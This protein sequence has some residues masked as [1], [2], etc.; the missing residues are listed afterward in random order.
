[1][2]NVVGDAY[3]VVRAITAGVERDI[4]DAFNG[5]DR[6][7]SRAGEN[8]GDS[9]RKGFGRN[10]DRGLFSIAFQR[11]ALQAKERLSSLIRIG[12]VLGPVLTGLSGILGILITGFTSLVSTIGASLLPAL[13]VTIQSF[14]ALTQ[15]V[16]TLKLAFA[17]V[18]KAIQAGNKAQKSGASN[19]KALEKALKA[20]ERARRSLADTI[21]D[22]DKREVESKKR[23][24]EAEDELS[25][26]RQQAIED[27]QQLGFDSEDAAIAEQ[28][29]A[30]ELEKAREELA[31]VSDLPPNSRARKE[32]ELAFA[33]ADLNYRRA[34]DRNNDLKKEETK[35]AELAK[36][37]PEALIDGQANV[38][39]ALKGVADAEDALK[40]TK[41]QNARAILAATEARDDAKDAVKDVQDGASAADAY[42]DAL[43]ELSPEAQRFV[44]YIVSLREEFKKLKAA[45]GK[46][47]FP[48]LEEAIQN[49]VDNL[50]P[51]LIPLLQSTGSVLGDIAK[52]FSETITRGE[53]LERL[54][55]IWKSNE[56]VLW[57]FG[58]AASNLYE[59]LLILLD[60]ARPLTEEFSAFLAAKTAA[61]RESLKLQ[62]STGELSKK[63][64][65]ARQTL[66]DL[67][68]ILGNTF[69]GLNN[70]F[71]ENVGPGSGGQIFLD[72]LKDATKAFENLE[73][74]DGKPVREFFADA[75]VNGTKF[76]S[77][78]GNIIGGFI[79][80]TD[81]AEL[82][83]FFD[84]LNTVTDIIQRIGEDISNS[85]P[86]F[87]EFLIQFAL[88]TETLTDSGSI[89]T[90]FDILAGVLR[91]INNF[92]N[93]EFGQALLKVT[94]AILPV[95]A[96]LGFVLKVSK[97]FGKAVVGAFLQIKN[98]AAALGFVIARLK[99]EFA[100][101][102]YTLGLG[103]GP[104]LAIIAAVAALVAIVVLAYQKSEVFREALK[105]LVEGVLVALKRAFDE[106]L[107]AIQEVV[108][109]I[110]SFGDIFKKI[111]D[112]LGKYIVPL[113]EVVLVGAIDLVAG[114]IKLII[115]VAGGLIEAFKVPF[116]VIKGI[117]ALFR[118]D[119]K[120]AAD[121]FK[122]AFEAAVNAIKRIFGGLAGFFKDIINA[123]IIRPW[124]RLVGGLSFKLPGILG[125]GTISLP[126]LNELAQGGVVYPQTGGTAA[127]LAEA[128]RPERIEPLDPQ[129]LS[130]RDRAIINELAG[131]GKGT[132]V[133]VTVNPS[134]GMDEREL[135]AIVSRQI[136][137][138]LRRGAA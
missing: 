65:I 16:L 100:M 22:A 68:T 31:R 40:E 62:E 132:T 47:L 106:I 19:A 75:A 56:I 30:L 29:A 131:P 46:E 137:F 101:L 64:E 107:E 27:L 7:G 121:A 92:L 20:L 10:T 105:T 127:L 57:N 76:L 39:E 114:A 63:F 43:S 49:L 44:K 21:E 123:A 138:Q 11:S 86:A 88:I 67:G 28:K 8:V 15:A 13:A 80:L 42:A 104:T 35:N 130:A 2:A 59:V 52:E 87:G 93:T 71:L 110:G 84:Q 103:A 128:G 26:A 58:D 73:T 115:R 33:Q 94:A 1:M 5:L 61:Y 36:K 74:I 116:N 99:Q 98:A 134:E 37:G 79:T 125:G 135:A 89:E 102:T 54:E 78:L 81:N 45:A 69:R 120:G 122:N 3:V 48:K 18:G 136:A 24:V 77:L 111:G 25:K 117:F 60:T 32:A 119:T 82:G 38:I 95:L 53:N 113:L 6:V 97:F 85:L 91:N 34:I 109:S 17:G 126:K 118:G 41:I 90:Y 55:R 133:N 12:Y 129:G 50:F 72:Y 23:L 4:R 66:K 112:F 96:A 9:F 83:V 70:L 124:N 108:P 51:R 14:S